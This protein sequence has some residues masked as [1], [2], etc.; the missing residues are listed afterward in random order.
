MKDLSVTHEKDFPDARK[1]QQICQSLLIVL[2]SPLPTLFLKSVLSWLCDFLPSYR[3]MALI[4]GL[5]FT[6]HP[7]DTVWVLPKGP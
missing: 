2:T 1:H 6:L 3:R 4:L 7:A 5:P